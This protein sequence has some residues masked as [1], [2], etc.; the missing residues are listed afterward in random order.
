MLTDEA[1]KAIASQ[2][3]AHKDTVSPTLRG[4]ADI[5]A[6]VRVC[7]AAELAARERQ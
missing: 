6:L 3:L 5:V 1:I 2:Y 7:L 4:W